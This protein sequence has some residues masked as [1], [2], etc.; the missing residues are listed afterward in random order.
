MSSPSHAG[1]SDT[2][3]RDR[4]TL[5]SFAQA[6][7]S[8]PPLSRPQLRNT[9]SDSMPVPTDANK[10]RAR[11][12]ESLSIKN[13]EEEVLNLPDDPPS[14]PK[15]SKK[16]TSHSPP[17]TK[18]A[19][20]RPK[21]TLSGHS[22][23]NEIPEYSQS[24]VA[25]TLPSTGSFAQRRANLTS[26][27]KAAPSALS[28]NPPAQGSREARLLGLEPIVR[29]APPVPASR[30]RLHQVQG[31]QPPSFQPAATGGLPSISRVRFGATYEIS[32]EA[33]RLPQV[34]KTA[35]LMGSSSHTTGGGGIQTTVQPPTPSTAGILNR[36]K[37]NNA[38]QVPLVPPTPS[39]LRHT[40]N[41]THP[42][43]PVNAGPPTA[44]IRSSA[45]SSQPN[46]KQAFLQ[47]FEAFYD[48]LSDAK[49]LK[50]WLGEQLSRS[51]ALL[52]QQQ[53]AGGS[54]SV[55]AKFVEDLVDQKV[56]GLKHD[57]DYLRE[58]VGA[59][60]ETLIRNGI[61]VPPP[62]STPGS[63][64]RANGSN[65]RKSPGQSAF[66]RDRELPPPSTSGNSLRDPFGQHRRPL[67]LS[68]SA[69]QTVLPPASSISKLT[70]SSSRL[71][72]LPPSS[73]NQ[74][75]PIGRSGRVPSP[76]RNSPHSE[77]EERQESRR[78]HEDKDDKMN[79]T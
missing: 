74:L 3:G 53:T 55:S 59:L 22:I 23:L 77:G 14:K 44:D 72:P 20:S 45:H 57:V 62:V 73:R 38:Q 76:L 26:S 15:R 18:H 13:E 2:E 52:Q 17:H 7:P 30:M 58:R 16:D 1:P 40:L 67:S 78:N 34:P 41:Q 32:S 8:S 5:P 48:A 47:P 25:Q 28:I 4:Q 60:E 29:S 61:A 12:D 79:V 43:H 75:P 10:K 49:S 68:P 50:D 33:A 35:G 54:A 42:R 46:P 66:S 65:P 64:S 70:M 9:L 36:G 21:H 51:N 37:D 6:F 56:K 63:L 31:S 39:S 24:K 69:Q 11:E 19:L 27:R 71:D